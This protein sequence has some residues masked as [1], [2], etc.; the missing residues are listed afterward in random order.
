MTAGRRIAWRCPGC[1]FLHSTPACVGCGFKTP[2]VRM[3]P[4]EW[5]VALRRAQS[6]G[7]PWK[8]G[9]NR[10][11]E[12]PGAPNGSLEDGWA[13]GAG[14]RPRERVAPGLRP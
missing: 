1:R 3:E 4:E 10:R 8:P 2:G 12:P 7:R 6:G 5:A 9:K 11:G 14:D 13:G